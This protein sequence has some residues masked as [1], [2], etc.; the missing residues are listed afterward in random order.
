MSISWL[1]DA[2]A[3][4]NLVAFCNC[5]CILLYLVH[6]IF[7][8]M[9]GK[10]RKTTSWHLRVECMPLSGWEICMTSF[11]KLLE[12]ISKLS[13]FSVSFCSIKNRSIQA[14]FSKLACFCTTVNIT[15]F[16]STI[17]QFVLQ[18]Q[19]IHSS[20]T[21]IWESDRIPVH[22]GDFFWSASL[23]FSSCPV[24]PCGVDQGG[25]SSMETG[26]L[27]GLGDMKVVGQCSLTNAQMKSPALQESPF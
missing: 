1:F 12:N 19:G 7:G 17:I 11:E 26:Q 18:D 16:F 8:S 24:Q 20:V 6:K 27:I 4:C 2:S 22:E 25:P 9:E 13:N 15:L 5:F 21:Y 3:L 23:C 10:V 14:K